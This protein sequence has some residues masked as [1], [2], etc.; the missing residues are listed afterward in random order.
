MH[1]LLMVFT[2][3]KPTPEEIDQILTPYYEENFYIKVD[4]SLFDTGDS[5]EE[6]R[7]PNPNEKPFHWDWYEIG[8]RFQTAY[9]DDFPEDSMAIRDMPIMHEDQSQLTYEDYGRLFAK[10]IDIHGTPYARSVW[11]CG[12]MH[13]DPRWGFTAKRIFQQAA[14]ADGWATVVDIH[15]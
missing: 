1:D 6:W 8:G 9:P 5:E 2:K 4:G 13:V 3:K 12:S 11:V 14:E 15:W 7:E 10:A